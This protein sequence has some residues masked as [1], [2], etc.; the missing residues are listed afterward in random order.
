VL[1]FYYL[2]QIVK[3][4]MSLYSIFTSIDSQE[5]FIKREELMSKQFHKRLNYGHIWDLGGVMLTLGKNH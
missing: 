4:H 5:T 1:A 2:P 3:K